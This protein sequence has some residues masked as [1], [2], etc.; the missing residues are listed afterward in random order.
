MYS[1]CL[2]CN[3]PLG[4][5]EVIEHL[6]I[7]RRV[8]FDSSQGR[9]W[10][11][12]RHCAKWNL[13]P[14]D[15][16]LE[17]I[18]ECER[19]YRDTPTRYS[20]GEIGLARHREG[21]DLVRI[22]PAMRPE[23]AAWRY[24]EQYRRRRRRTLVLG[25]A[26]LMA[27]SFAVGAAG[28]ALGATVG[29]TAASYLTL[30]LGEAA[31]RAVQRRRTGLSV[32]DPAQVRTL[33]ISPERVERSMITWESEQPVVEVPVGFGLFLE[34]GYLRWEGSE[35]RSQG[36]RLLASLNMF[37]GKARDLDAATQ[38][39][40]EHSGDLIPWLREVTLRDARIGGPNASWR[41]PGNEDSERARQLQH[42]YLRPA[43]LPTHERLAVE[44]WMNEDIERTWLEGELKLL[45]REWREAE[46]I[47]KIADDLVLV[48]GS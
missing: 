48:P 22:G 23:F 7:G 45:E 17:S 16:R 28:V 6:P 2:H 41:F 12:C 44:M 4:T 35:L 9:L 21:L 5:N 18:D 46:R 14:F 15:T 40:A 26:G 31:L 13:V 19:I 33:R 42:P 25:G 11:I 27:G 3:K 30:T 1:T 8:A 10:V 36:R 37:A 24:G 20:T 47:A 32:H 38:I 43:W 39:V 34:R 29:M